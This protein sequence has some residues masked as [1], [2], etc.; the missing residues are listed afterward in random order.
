MSQLT[1]RIRFSSLLITMLVAI[2]LTELRAPVQANSPAAPPGSD[3]TLG[4][5]AGA[6]S[7]DR[8]LDPDGT[9]DMSTGFEGT[10]DLRGWE[11]SIF[12]RHGPIDFRPKWSTPRDGAGEIPA[13]NE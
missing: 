13:E 6:V 4:A 11:L 5:P 1:R 2:L 8:L 12:A 7:P 10:L 3:L 9:L